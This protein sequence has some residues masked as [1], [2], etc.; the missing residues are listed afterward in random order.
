MILIRGDLL[1]SLRCSGHLNG[2][3]KNHPQV[4]YLV[5]VDHLLLTCFSMQCVPGREAGPNVNET[6]VQLRGSQFV[7]NR[8]H[9]TDKTLVGAEWVFEP[10]LWS[11]DSNQPRG[12]QSWAACN[13]K[14]LWPHL[15]Q[16]RPESPGVGLGHGYFSKLLTWLLRFVYHERASGMSD[17]SL[18]IQGSDPA[19]TVNRLNLAPCLCL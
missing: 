8:A 3:L 14:M 7:W 12:S 11:W 2:G 19:T 15:R 6:L 10:L 16:V 5:R 17:G 13:K 18:S 1:N 9:C 4:G